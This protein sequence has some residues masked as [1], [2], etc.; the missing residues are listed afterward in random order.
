MWSIQIVIWE[1]KRW[2]KLYARHK[3]HNMSIEDRQKIRKRNKQLLKVGDVEIKKKK[4]QS[5]W[6]M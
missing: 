5:M 3:N 4:F 6:V 1:R 2:K